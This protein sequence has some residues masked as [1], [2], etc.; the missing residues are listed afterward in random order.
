MRCGAFGGELIE[1]ATRPLGYWSDGGVIEI[2][3][4]GGPRELRRAERLERL[5]Q[6]AHVR[7]VIRDFPHA[8]RPSARTSSASRSPSPSRLRPSTARPIATP[9]AIETH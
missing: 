3:R 8:T 7:G 6:G 5:A 4:I 1:C 9:G 2:G